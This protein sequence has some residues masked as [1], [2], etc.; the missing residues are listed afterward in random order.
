MLEI[1]SSIIPLDI[2]A[3]LASPMMFAI[4]IFLL[5]QK[6]HSKAKLTAFFIP[7][8]LISAFVT[9][10]GYTVGHTVPGT[11]E[12]NPT[13]RIIDLIIGFLFL[14]LAFRAWVAKERK[15]RVDHNPKGKKILK[16]FIIS[17]V[18]NITN[19][20]ALFLIAAA[21]REVG[22]FPDISKLFQWLLLLLN[23]L[24]YTLPIT[25]PVIITTFFPSL[26]K[27]VL[28]AMT[29]FLK[30]YSRY[31]ITGMFLLLGLVFLN[32]GLPIIH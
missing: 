11:K 5:S 27:H 30:T 19:I 8:F 14:F 4:A 26:A 2:A 31:I 7:A 15:P 13:E 3:I 6:Y 12:T 16:W 21:G 1:F 24:F 23:T 20:D 10:A 18:L 32:K 9:F 29:L 22:N 25:F 28:S 17:L